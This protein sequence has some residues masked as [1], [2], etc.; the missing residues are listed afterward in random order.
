M[1]VQLLSQCGSTSNCLCRSVPEIHSPVA[2]TLGKQPTNNLAG[3]ST[4]QQ[5]ASVSQ[6]RNLKC[7]SCQMYLRNS[8]I[9]SVSHAKSISGTQEYQV[10]LM[11]SASHPQMD[12]Q[13]RNAVVVAAVVVVSWLFSVPATCKVY[14]R[15][16]LAWT[17]LYATIV[18]ANQTC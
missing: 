15:N 12:N 1:D 7:F 4:S 14:L 2:G 13:N 6:V 5:H 16:E 8:G 11:P 9:S 10:C 3:C 17:N 18:L